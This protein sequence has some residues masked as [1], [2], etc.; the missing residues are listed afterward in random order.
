M[1]SIISRIWTPLRARLSTERASFQ[2]M[3]HPMRRRRALAQLARL[4]AVDSVVFV[5]LGNVCRSPYAEASLRGR[6]EGKQLN[7]SSVGFIGPGRPPPEAALEVASELGVDHID[8]RSQIA[9]LSALNAASIVFV[10]D[11]QNLQRLRALGFSVPERTMY[12]G[13]LD[14]VWDGKRPIWDPWGSPPDAFRLIF[15]RIDR[16]LDVFAAGI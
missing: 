14:P 1:E 2:G 8:H 6:V 3:L 16:C 9:T 13:D 15:K 7:I 4:Q 10:F 12:L 11:R 5:C